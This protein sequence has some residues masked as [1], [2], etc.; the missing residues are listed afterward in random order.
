MQSNDGDMI[1]MLDSA[2]LTPRYWLSFSLFCASFALDYFDY[3]IVG[4]LVA[5]IGPQWHL[6]YL[7][8]SIM[9][10]S[11]GVGSIVGALV[12]GAVADRVGRRLPVA[13]A[14]LI[15]G[16][17]SLAIAF[18]P[19]DA[20][21][22]FSI[23]RFGVG[24]GLAGAAASATAL[25][26]EITPTRHRVRLTGLPIVA[27]ALGTLLASGVAAL[28]LAAIGWRGIAAV[29]TLPAVIGLLIAA[30]VPESVRWLVTKG[31]VAE[32][33]STAA[34]VLGVPEDRLILPVVTSSAPQARF[35]EVFKRPA[36]F[37]FTVVTWICA[38]TAIYGVYLWGPA[39]V[40]MLLHISPG[41]AARYFVVVAATGLAGKILY[42]FLPVWTGRRLAGQIHGVG[43]MV[44]LGAA[45]LF[46]T[47]MIGG[48]FP[49]FVV[50]IA[51]GACFFDGGFASLAPYTA[52]IFPVRLSGSGLGLAQAS[53]GV[54]K[55]VGPLC[56]ALI[57]GAD[58]LVTPAATEAAILPAFLF[59]AGTG[60]VIFFCFTFLAPETSGRALML[61]DEDVAAKA[62]VAE[63][64]HTA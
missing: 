40:A 4:F 29:G 52:E 44:T 8:S 13:A 20:W 27:T 14:S 39:I 33:R 48:S 6:T 57:A 51:L 61:E 43:I 31:R 63:M 47:V 59:L 10:L 24:F 9:L 41:E 45:G 28:L 11:A 58:N 50:L 15:C 34:K 60:L 22:L 32:A 53:N 3:F 64:H 18:I 19:N 30:F 23:F 16:A 46:S 7:Q 12:C 42:S 26:M 38:S 1:A 37:W 35:T 56:L 36:R 25:L 55:I 54:G 17:S 49:L 62:P 21:Q 5:V 2:P